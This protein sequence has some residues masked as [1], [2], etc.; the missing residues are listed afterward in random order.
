LQKNVGEGIQVS[1]EVTAITEYLKNN[2]R[3]SNLTVV[4][5]K[6]R[7]VLEGGDEKQTQ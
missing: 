2:E 4:M 3:K 1:D 7:P 5:G 6:F